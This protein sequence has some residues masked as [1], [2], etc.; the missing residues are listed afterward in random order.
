MAAV[1]VERTAP[2]RM[3]TQLPINGTLKPVLLS[4]SSS[5]LMMT[6]GE[7]YRLRYEEHLESE[8]KSINLVFGKLVDEAA[9]AFIKA[10]VTGDVIDPLALFEAQF[11]AM[12]DAVELQL[13]SRGDLD[14]TRLMGRQ[15]LERFIE[16][17]TARG[18]LP[19]LDLDGQPI[20]QRWLRVQLPENVVYRG[21]IDVIVLTPEGK[22][23]IVD[24]KTTSAHVEGFSLVG[25]QLTGYQVMV[26]AHRESLGIERVDGLLYYD[27]VKRAPVTEK[28]RKGATGP[29]IHV[30]DPAPPRSS[31]H[32]EAWVRE[33]L[34]IASDIRQ[35]R[36]SKRPGRPFSTP[37]AMCDFKNLCWHGDGTSLVT[38]QTTSGDRE[39]P[40]QQPLC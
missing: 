33:Q 4:D 14:T 16:D 19:M 22:V 10:Q 32:L 35:R 18:W 5:A 1:M 31:D 30:D 7:Q 37:C 23:L 13:T 24:L 11:A 28:S 34:F 26:E 27:M 3:V 20:V 12:T 9:S 40:S 15:M 29:T 21:V 38:R 8:R 25:D 39:A 6:C 17:R 2:V 36:F